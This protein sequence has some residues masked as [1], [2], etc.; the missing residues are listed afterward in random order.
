M[1]QYYGV[2][3]AGSNC[4]LYSSEN[5]KGQRERSKN[6]DFYKRV[7]CSTGAHILTSREGG[8]GPRIQQRGFWQTSAGVLGGD[9]V[10]CVSEKLQA[11]LE[12]VADILQKSYWLTQE[13]VRKQKQDKEQNTTVSSSYSFLFFIF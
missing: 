12:C 9:D 13:G 5:K 7:N 1:V 4:C 8:T 10:D 6:S 11:E 2:A 3:A